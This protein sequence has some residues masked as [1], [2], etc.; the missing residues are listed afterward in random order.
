M[1]ESLERAN[2]FLVPMDGER[3]WH[4]YHRLFADVLQAHLTVRGSWRR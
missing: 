4:R 3:R 2:L 1:L